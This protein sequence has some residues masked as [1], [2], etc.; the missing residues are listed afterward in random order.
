M[1]SPR[2]DR[3]GCEDIGPNVLYPPKEQGIRRSLRRSDT[4]D[5]KDPGRGETTTSKGEDYVGECIRK[6]VPAPE[7]RAPERNYGWLWIASRCR[8]G[9]RTARDGTNRVTMSKGLPAAPDDVVLDEARWAQIVPLL[10]LDVVAPFFRSMGL[11]LADDKAFKELVRALILEVRREVAADRS[12]AAE[13]STAWFLDRFGSAFGA[14]L[15]LTCCVGS[16]HFHR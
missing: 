15:G 5:R 8:R 1:G 3:C 7:A 2:L 16:V 13:Y 4:G 11:Q 6:M 10:S 9:R 14:D 12:K